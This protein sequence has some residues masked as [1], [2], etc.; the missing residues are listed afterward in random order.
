MTEQTD[1]TVTT[2]PK[3]SR[4]S[5]INKKTAS[6]VLAVTGVG[7]LGAVYLKRKLNCSCDVDVSASVTNADQ[8]DTN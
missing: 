3:Q 6:K 4:F 5:R 7:L 8:P 1:A 2:L